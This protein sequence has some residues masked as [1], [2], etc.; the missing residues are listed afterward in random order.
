MNT[1]LASLL[2]FLVVIFADARVHDRYGVIF[3]II[4]VLVFA[5]VSFWRKGE[6]LREER[7]LSILWNVLIVM[8]AAV[9]VIRLLL[10]YSK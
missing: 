4:A 10:G 9:A 5:A 2:L 3:W 8:A 1:R 7:W 6:I